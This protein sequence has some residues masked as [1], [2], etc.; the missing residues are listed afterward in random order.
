ME[1]IDLQ[2]L[3]AD[4]NLKNFEFAERIGK[5]SQNV[6]HVIRRKALPKGWENL[7]KSAFPDI[8]IEKYITRT[9]DISVKYFEKRH[10]RND[11]YSQ[12]N[13][14]HVPIHAE[15]G[16]LGGENGAVQSDDLEPWMYPGLKGKCF[17]FIVKGDSMFPTLDPCDLIIAS[18]DAVT[19]I[20]ELQNNYMYAISLDGGQILVKRVKLHP[21]K[22]RVILTSDNKSY[23]DQELPLNQKYF[24]MFKVRRIGKWNASM[25]ME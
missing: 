5:G 2:R 24:K 15:A 22:D 20:T 14:L 16:F 21:N 4:L 13:V 9:P 12:Y 8:N 3:I 11:N 17:S 1:T 18:Q 19:S 6:S 7:I 10:N 23:Q 25:R